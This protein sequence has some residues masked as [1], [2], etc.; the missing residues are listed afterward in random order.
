MRE[1]LLLYTR[2]YSLVHAANLGA[3]FV[4][5]HLCL[6]SNHQMMYSVL[7]TST[8]IPVP[9]PYTHPPAALSIGYEGSQLSS[10]VQFIPSL[11]QARDRPSD[12]HPA[13]HFVC[14]VCFSHFLTGLSLNK[15][16]APKSLS[17]A[18][19]LGSLT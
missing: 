14:P 11:H 5:P 1:V 3:V 12:P 18:L 4:P 15:P 6:A 2:I 8:Q 9:G 13:W 19:L 7:L 16:A 10:M 17:L